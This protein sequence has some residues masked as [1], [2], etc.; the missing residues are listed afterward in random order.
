[1]YV[2]KLM[3]VMKSEIDHERD[4]EQK[5]KAIGKKIRVKE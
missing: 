2:M 3:Q 5:I 1:M 4:Y